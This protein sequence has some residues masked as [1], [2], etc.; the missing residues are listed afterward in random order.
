VASTYATM[1]ALDARTGIELWSYPTGDVIY[2]DP[3]VVNGVL[4]FASYDAHI[5][6]C[7]LKY[8]SSEAKSDS[9]RPDL[10]TLRPDFSLN[11]SQPVATAL[12]H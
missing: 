5:Y 12:P 2:S 7:G 11:M 1:Y 10:K 3:T 8:G 6:A 4:Y 9:E